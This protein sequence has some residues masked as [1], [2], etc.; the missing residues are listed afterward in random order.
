[1]NNVHNSNSINAIQ[2]S[3]KTTIDLKKSKP[4]KSLLF[5]SMPC[6]RRTSAIRNRTVKSMQANDVGDVAYRYLQNRQGARNSVQEAV[7]W[8]FH[9]TLSIKFLRQCPKISLP[10]RTAIVCYPVLMLP[11]NIT[12]SLKY[13]ETK[14]A[15]EVWLTNK[16]EK[17]K[18]EEIEKFKLQSIRNH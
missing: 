17:Q 9:A 13:R 15:C 18:F 3:C 6:E 14:I 11:P 4:T 2:N 1:M 16:L 5:T 8:A 12:N 7:F 10:V